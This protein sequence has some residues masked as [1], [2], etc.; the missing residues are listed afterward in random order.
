MFGVIDGRSKLAVLALFPLALACASGDTRIDNNASW[1]PGSASAGPAD[2]PNAATGSVTT[3]NATGG[4]SGANGG[5]SGSGSGALADSS[6]GS[7]MGEECGNGIIE[8]GEACDGNMLADAACTDFG[9]DGG[10][11]VCGSECV[12]L[13]DGCSSC[14]D[15]NVALM[16]V[17]DGNDLGGETCVSL[18]FGGGA[19]ACDTDCSALNTGGCVPLPSCGDGMLNGGEQCD[20]PALGGNSCVTEGFDLG[21]IACTASC[22][23]DISD[24]E[25]DLANCTEQGDFCLFDEDNLQSTCCPPGVGGNI[26]GICDIFLC[27]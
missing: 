9:F 17:C 8:G 27:L 26:L 20:G 3:V 24:C 13:T 22:T 14:G 23:L 1:G 7:E 4:G 19:L 2:A 5:S 10:S 15:G 11:V 25:D 21:A 18:G 6:G 12:V 16:E